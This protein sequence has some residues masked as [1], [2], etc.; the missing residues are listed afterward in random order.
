MLSAMITLTTVVFPPIWGE[1]ISRQL[2]KW[3][4]C[5]FPGFPSYSEGG[6]FETKAEVWDFG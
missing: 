2:S 6:Y 5:K 4:V 1:V 3:D